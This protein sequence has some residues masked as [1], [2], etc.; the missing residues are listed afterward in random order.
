M[1]TMPMSPG[2]QFDP[3]VGMDGLSGSYSE[4]LPVRKDRLDIPK[5]NKTAVFSKGLQ[6]HYLKAEPVSVMACYQNPEKLSRLMTLYSLPA[7]FKD[8]DERY[9]KVRLD[10]KHEALIK[11][12]VDQNPN[13]IRKFASEHAVENPFNL[14]G[15][16][17]SDK[18]G[19]LTQEEW[20]NAIKN[21]PKIYSGSFS[22]SMKL[23]EGI[24]PASHQKM[25]DMTKNA[26]LWELKNAEGG[27]VGA[28]SHGQ[29]KDLLQMDGPTKWVA[30][31][32]AKG[33]GY[34]GIMLQP[35]LLDE[36][37]GL[38]KVL[39]DNAVKQTLGQGG[40]HIWLSVPDNLHFANAIENEQHKGTAV[41]AEHLKK[42]VSPLI[43]SEWTQSGLSVINLMGQKLYHIKL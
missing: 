17:K 39:V 12:F 30:G 16:S 7:S 1:L 35:H 18:T 19:S 10:P 33:H 22:A 4:P 23:M 6:E 15:N 32:L 43:K 34:T 40:N 25:I 31:A 14:F 8:F 37:Q 2:N 9:Q 28:I 3:R 11:K 41:T 26:S 29:I 36:K 24:D 20:E 13:V 42:E 5:G 27:L 38:A 21:I